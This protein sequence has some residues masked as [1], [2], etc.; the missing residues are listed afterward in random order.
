MSS[1][2]ISARLDT[3]PGLRGKP[4]GIGP[5]GRPVGIGFARAAKAGNTG[6][7]APR[8]SLSEPS[9]TGSWTVPPGSTRSRIGCPATARASWT[10]TGRGPTVAG[11]AGSDERLRESPRRSRSTWTERIRRNE[12]NS[13]PTRG[14][15][16]GP[17]RPIG[18]GKP[19]GPIGPRGPAIPGSPVAPSSPAIP[20]IPRIPIGPSG[21]KGPIGPCGPVGPIGRSGRIALMTSSISA[22]QV[23]CPGSKGAVAELQGISPGS[24]GSSS[25][26]LAQNATQMALSWRT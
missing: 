12:A 24:G 14:R 19:I 16:S 21:P 11:E 25:G 9:M 4:G 17:G 22:T 8:G 5:P 13:V 2:M 23:G 1:R 6:R 7:K 18:P 3:R 20:A 26:K 15:P 10:A